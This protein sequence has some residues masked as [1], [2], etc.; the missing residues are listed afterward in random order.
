ME[1]NEEYVRASWPRVQC[2]RYEE[3]FALDIDMANGERILARKVPSIED[4]WRIGA[5]FTRERRKQ[6]EAL[7]IVV[8][9]LQSQL[10]ELKK[11]LRIS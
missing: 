5:E 1:S 3:G 2:K 8:A 7:E 9:M 4:G 6:V 11:G 10:T